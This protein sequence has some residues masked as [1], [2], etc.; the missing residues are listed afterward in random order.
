MGVEGTLYQTYQRHWTW[1]VLVLYE[2]K[3][4]YRL[5]TCF[6]NADVPGTQ[7]G[8]NDDCRNKDVSFSYRPRN[9]R[10][11]RHLTSTVPSTELT[12]AGNYSRADGVL[13]GAGTI[14]KLRFRSKPVPLEQMSH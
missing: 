10:S 7:Y 2:Q 1:Y 8:Y 3:G 11:V 6:C 13:G 5:L 14:S 12:I 9:C 4:V